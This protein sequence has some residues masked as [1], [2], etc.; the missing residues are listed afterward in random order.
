VSDGAAT[1]AQHAVAVAGAAVF[2][3][4]AHAAPRVRDLLPLYR[5][6]LGGVLV[7]GADHARLG[8]RVVHLAFA[9]GTKIELL[10]PLPGSAFFDRFFEK[11]PTGGL[12]HVTFRVPDLAAAVAEAQRAGF[13]LFGVSDERPE[14]KEAFIHPRVAS[15]TL[16]QFAEVAPGFPSVMSVAAVEAMIVGEGTPT[17]HD[18]ARD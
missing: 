8:Y 18:V 15:G 10:E 4:V 5:D 16:V 12:H 14:W 13:E 17:A 7:H 6:V 2:D 3:H 1:A 11:N 9:G